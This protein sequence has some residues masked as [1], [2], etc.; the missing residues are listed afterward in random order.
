VALMEAMARTD[1]A[2]E[3]RI[4]FCMAVLS[5]RFELVWNLSRFQ[6]AHIHLRGG[7][8]AGLGLFVGCGENLCGSSDQG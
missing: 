6:S 7:G 5:F 8:R 2:T 4:D 3:A 1:A